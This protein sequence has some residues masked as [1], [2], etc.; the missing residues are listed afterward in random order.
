MFYWLTDNKISYA[1]YRLRHAHVHVHVLNT[2]DFAILQPYW[3]GFDVGLREGGGGGS[4]PTG[5]NIQSELKGK[6]IEIPG[7][8]Q[9]GDQPWP[10][11][12]YK[13]PRDLYHLLGT[14]QIGPGLVYA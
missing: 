4:A 10:S 1:V 13:R 2:I 9:G 3:T 14:G 12:A 11:I 8:S 7:P 6:T 5:V